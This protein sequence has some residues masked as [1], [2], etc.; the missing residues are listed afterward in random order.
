M[1]NQK[2]ASLVLILAASAGI[3]ACR[4]MPETTLPDGSV[5]YRISCDSSPSGMNYCFERAGK[6]C[7]AAGYTV[8]DSEGRTLV[9][10]GVTSDT[11]PEALVR[12]YQMDTNS[13]LV[14]CGN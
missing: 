14:K 5:A 11:D 8:V 2:I 3:S 1:L 9:R 6:T 7:G 4:G 12:S 10:G 13:I